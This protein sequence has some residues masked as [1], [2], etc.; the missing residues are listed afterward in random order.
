[1]IGT[2]YLIQ[3]FIAWG[4]TSWFIVDHIEDMR[5]KALVVV[6]WTLVFLFIMR[7]LI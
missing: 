2:I 6:I 1:M 4:L 5:I 7:T 3:S